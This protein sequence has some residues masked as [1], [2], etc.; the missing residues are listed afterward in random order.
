MPKYICQKLNNCLSAIS[1]CTVDYDIVYTKEP[2]NFL[3]EI[4]NSALDC[5]IYAKSIGGA[6]FW[7]WNHQNKACYPKTSDS[8]RT[9]AS[10]SGT[11]S[12]TV[13]C[14]EAGGAGKHYFA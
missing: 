1:G 3:Y 8:G 10:P 11:T 14:G 12:G 5:A 4:V 6:F 2:D 9:A 7:S 13:A